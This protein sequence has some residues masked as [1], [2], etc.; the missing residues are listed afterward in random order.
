MPGD[1]RAGAGGGQQGGSSLPLSRSFIVQFSRDTAP[2]CRRFRG[3]V[4]QLHSGRARRF[5][6]LDDLMLF[7]T[8]ILDMGE[9]DEDA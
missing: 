1:E 4:E 5:D 7:V 8:Q 6:S 2:S 3:R 9:S